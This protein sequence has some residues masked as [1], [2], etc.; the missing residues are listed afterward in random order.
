MKAQS[1]KLTIAN[2]VVHYW[3]AGHSNGRTVTLIHGGLADAQA[4]WYKVFPLLA[5]E[6]HLLAPD[7]PGFG[8]SQALK[9]D[10]IKALLDWLAAFLDAVGAEQTVL[11]GNSF[12]GLLARLFAAEYP[13]RV[14]ALILMNGGMVP[15]VPAVAR[16]ILRLP[17]IGSGLL[18]LMS[19]RAS[20]EAMLRRLVHVQSAVTPQLIESALKNAQGFRDLMRMA[21]LHSLPANRVPPVNT[22]ILWGVEDGVVGL[23]AAKKLQAQ[24]RGSK[25][26]EIADCGHMPQLEAPD[27]FAFQLQKFLPSQIRQLDNFSDNV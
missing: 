23:D 14:P 27:V 24:L 21:S 15:N 3:E 2:K 1:K 26:V 22:L 4:N 16:S 8:E 10:D 18:Q 25:L 17:L 20:S 19:R 12:G 11:V 9:A 7:L 13:I 6:Y 5:D